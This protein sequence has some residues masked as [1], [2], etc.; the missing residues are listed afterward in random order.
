MAGEAKQ[1]SGAGKFFLG[2]PAETV[3]LDRY[4]P[5]QNDII[6]KSASMASNL[7]GNAS[8]DP[9]ER[10]ARQNFSQQAVPSLAER[11]TSM[12]AKGSSA[13]GQQ[14]G[15]AQANL[16]SN[17]A[18]GRANYDQGLLKQLLD[19]GLTQQF[20]S[21]Y[22]PEQEGFLSSLGK[23]LPQIA[24]RLGLAYATGGTSEMGEL[25][26][27]IPFL[28]KL[29]GG[30]AEEGSSTNN[31]G[32]NGG[33][34]APTIGQQPSMN[35]NQ[36]TA[37]LNNLLSAINGPSGQSQMQPTGVPWGNQQSLPSFG[38]TSS[39]FGNQ[40]SSNNTPALMQLLSILQNQKG[41]GL[42]WNSQY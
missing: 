11:F 42:P 21:I 32:G 10:Q 28:K 4:N 26:K 40:N 1:R 41:S 20:D 37:G 22:N 29:L 36:Q 23:Q 27:L 39:V 31:S 8:F 9:Y 18:T 33:P 3:K 12:G 6:N 24:T 13:F 16:E 30:T 17:L 34:I 25:G 7:L 14:L 5:Q 19:T 15:N 2:T 35:T 38:N